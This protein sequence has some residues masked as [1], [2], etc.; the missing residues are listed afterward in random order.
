MYSLLTAMDITRI[1][2]EERLEAALNDR[3]MRATAQMQPN[4]SEVQRSPLQQMR[5][6][7]DR[8]M[9]LFF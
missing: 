2:H 7:V 6:V 3:R 1:V 8:V 5:R 4:R 9:C